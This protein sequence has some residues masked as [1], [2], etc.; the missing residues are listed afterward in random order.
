M[1]EMAKDLPQD[2]DAERAVLGAILV[3]PMSW[4][5]VCDVVKSKDFYSVANQ[6]VFAACEELAAE[7]K[8]VDLVTV[9][10]WLRDTNRLEFVGGAHKVSELLDALPDVA[11]AE[12][13]AHIV[14]EKAVR[15]ALIALGGEI[16]D[17]ARKDHR[18]EDA[19]ATALDG[20]Y[21]I[22]NEAT[23][24]AMQEMG[25]I[26]PSQLVLADKL[27]R[28]EID[29]VGVPFGWHWLDSTGGM[30]RGELTVVSA[31]PSEGKTVFALNVARN[32]VMG[33]DEQGVA[34]IATMEMSKE[35]LTQRSMAAIAGVNSQIFKMRLDGVTL[36]MVDG[37]DGSIRARLQNSCD[38]L[39]GLPLL[40]DESPGMTPKM[41]RMRCKAIRERYG[42]LDLVMID[43]L[44]L[45]E[46]DDAGKGEEYQRV[47]T[48]TRKLKALATEM[49][50]TAFLV[51]SHP[52]SDTF[53]KSQTKHKDGLRTTPAVY[54]C[55]GSKEIRKTAYLMIDLARDVM[56]NGRLT[57]LTCVKNRGGQTW[58]RHLVLLKAHCKFE[59]PWDSDFPADWKHG[60]G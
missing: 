7:N 51:V 41:L 23:P 50:D 13:Y 35:E 32:V 21:D 39:A 36:D 58:T 48:I 55:A 33:G 19:I 43:Y 46:L 9:T 20:A 4:A 53:G 17:A 18:V 38:R 25:Q 22:A 12:D 59:R 34:L 2:Q 42:R 15:R 45:M 3:E 57:R 11:N 47:Q 6:M 26:A 5:M 31:Q 16:K 8:A 52:A 54:E 28:G 49:R 30:P 40:M 14:K 44:Q 1:V 37:S 24:V 29:V 10:G 60:R 56:G 27:D